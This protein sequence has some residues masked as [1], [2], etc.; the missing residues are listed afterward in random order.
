MMAA[1]EGYAE[2]EFQADVSTDLIFVE[3]R[4]RVLTVRGNKWRVTGECTVTMRRV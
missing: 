4:G 2:V 1:P 3:E